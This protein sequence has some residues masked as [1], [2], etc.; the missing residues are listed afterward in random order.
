MSDPFLRWGRGR[1]VE[2]WRAAVPVAQDKDSGVALQDA[3]WTPSD[4]GSLEQQPDRGGGQGPTGHLDRKGLRIGEA[5]G[6]W[7]RARHKG[8][9][10]PVLRM[11]SEGQSQPTVS[12]V[13]LPVAY[14]PFRPV[15]WAR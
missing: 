13:A 9:R 2:V 1:G 12:L 8:S 7:S 6:A 11:P 4:K 15:S 10:C 5:R 14:Q 3:W